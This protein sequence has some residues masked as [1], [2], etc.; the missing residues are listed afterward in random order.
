[1]AAPE[2]SGRIDPSSVGIKLHDG[3]STLVTLGK[4]RN[5]EFWEK[6]VTPP[7]LD[8]GDAI[9]QTT[10]FNATVRTMAPRSLYTLTESTITA[11]YDPDLYNQIQYAINRDDTITITFP[12]ESQLAFFGYLRLF[13][14]QTHEEGS[15]P[16]CNVTFTPT[17]WDSVNNIEAAP[18]MTEVA[19]T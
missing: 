18:V 19:G 11:A 10:M 13:E 12:D 17:N 1:M 3:F 7:G 5:I 9:E 14:P 15:Q 8:G 6:T 2:V 16:E 4:D